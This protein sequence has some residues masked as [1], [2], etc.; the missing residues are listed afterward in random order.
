MLRE[1]TNELI[2]KLRTRAKEKR[3]P[4]K[5]SYPAYIKTPANQ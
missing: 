1:I 2:L 5:S 4:I 3:E